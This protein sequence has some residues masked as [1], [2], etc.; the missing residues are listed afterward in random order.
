MRYCID[1][2]GSDMNNT[3]AAIKS[4]L[5][6][7]DRRAT[8]S[9]GLTRAERLKVR[10]L[11]AQVSAVVALAEARGDADVAEFMDDLG[12]EAA[13]RQGEVMA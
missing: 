13:R 3:I 9:L 12:I 2:K 8:K 6:K 5:S 7:A 10:N 11:L 1:R 4:D